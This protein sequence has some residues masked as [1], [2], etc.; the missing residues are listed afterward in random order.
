[1][2]E[3]KILEVE[4]HGFCHTVD[5]LEP[6][7]IVVFIWELNGGDA[8]FRANLVDGSRFAARG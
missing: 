6:K 5:K 3:G 1:M 8:G 4:L 7:P 2:G